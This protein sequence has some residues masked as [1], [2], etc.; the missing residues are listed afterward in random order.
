MKTSTLEHLPVAVIGAGPV[1]L[2]AAAQLISRGLP[3]KVYETGQLVGSNL[4][5]WGH[6][7][8]FTPW[9]YCLDAAATALLDRHDDPHHN[10]SVFT[11][12]GPSVF[13]ATCALAAAVG[14]HRYRSY[15]TSV[16]GGAVALPT[17]AWRGVSSCRLS[18]VHCSMKCPAR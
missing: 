16:D 8:V 1:G 7:R 12:G 15:Q 5:D 11:L 13:E 4:R 9:R 6:V 2:A 17:V 3:V 18:R 14:E 10:R